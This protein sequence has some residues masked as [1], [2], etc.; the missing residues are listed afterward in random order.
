VTGDDC[1][2]MIAYVRDVEH[3]EA[4]IDQFAAYGQTTSSIM[5][6]SPVPRRAVKPAA[7]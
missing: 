4:L 1:F 7:R 3:L 6:S 2:V 5:Q